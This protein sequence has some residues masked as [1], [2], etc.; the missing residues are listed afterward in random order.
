MPFSST[1]LLITLVVLPF[2]SCFNAECFGSLHFMLLVPN[3]MLKSS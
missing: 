3:P 2:S 1:I